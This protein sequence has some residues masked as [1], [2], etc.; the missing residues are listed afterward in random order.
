MRT[1]L[2]FLLPLQATTA[3]TQPDPYPNIRVIQASISPTDPTT[4]DTLTV[5]FQF[6]APSGCDHIR[7][8]QVEGTGS[9]KQLHVRVTRPPTAKCTADKEAKRTATMRIPPLPAGDYQLMMDGNWRVEGHQFTLG[10]MP[11]FFTV[12]ER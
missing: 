2:F 8:W 12:R 5:T 9:R 1:A 6:I 3:L 11:V 7:D 10:G 4:A